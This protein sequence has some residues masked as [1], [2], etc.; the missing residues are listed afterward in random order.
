MYCLGE[1]AVKTPEKSEDV[2][3]AK[4]TEEN[5]ESKPKVV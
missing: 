1:A 3:A 4:K 5:S 2:I